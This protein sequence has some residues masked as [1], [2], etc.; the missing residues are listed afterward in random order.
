MKTLSTETDSMIKDLE[1][2]DKLMAGEW[3]ITRFL[4]TVWYNWFG[5]RSYDETKKSRIRT[6]R[7]LIGELKIFK[8]KIDNNIKQLEQGKKG[9]MKAEDLRKLLDDGKKAVVEELH[10]STKE[11]TRKLAMLPCP[12]LEKSSKRMSG[13]ISDAKA[14]MSKK[15]EENKEEDVS[16]STPKHK[17]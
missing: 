11:I 5:D 2:Y 14:A 6:A 8:E 15:R 16:D 1:R 3:K 13:K 12:Q 4:K 9:E 17:A 10:G 7:E